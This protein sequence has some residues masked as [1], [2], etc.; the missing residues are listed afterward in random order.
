MAYLIVADKKRE[1]DRRKL[2]GRLIIGRCPDCDIAVRDILLSR[3]HCAIDQIGDHWVLV[4]LGSKNG[5]RVNG[6]AITRHM[7]A[8]GD[9]AQIG[10]IKL[11]FRAGSFV[12]AAT[13]PHSRAA[14]PAEPIEALAS[15][16]AGFKFADE[17]GEYDAQTA[18][19]FPRPQPQPVEPMSFRQPAVHTMLAEM[20]SQSTNA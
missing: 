12:P 4:D 11:C 14:R 5:T 3:R 6:E 2:A 13:T 19:N 10:K 8:D 17:S 16:V 1:L 7:L 18:R 20:T 15:T 9:V